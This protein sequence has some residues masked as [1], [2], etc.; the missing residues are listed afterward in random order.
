[1][2]PK[3]QRNSVAAQNIPKGSARGKQSRVPNA[4]YCHSNQI[5]MCMAPT[6]ASITDW[7]A[8]S[9]NSNSSNSVGGGLLLPCRLLRF[10]KKLLLNTTQRSLQHEKTPS[11]LRITFSYAVHRSTLFACASCIESC[12][13]L[14]TS[15]TRRQT[16]QGSLRSQSAGSCA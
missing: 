12:A 7:T 4:D 14:P 3:A 9:N 6:S 8:V 15:G 10:Q 2:R 1:M 16:V 13:T 11:R 5:M